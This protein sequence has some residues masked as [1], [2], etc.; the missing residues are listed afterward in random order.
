MNMPFYVAFYSYAKEVDSKVTAILDTQVLV[1]KDTVCAGLYS[2][3]TGECM[4]LGLGYHL[5]GVVQPPEP[6]HV[7]GMPLAKY[8]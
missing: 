2:V 4:G 1:D 8:A 7:D 5:D 6:P 3:S